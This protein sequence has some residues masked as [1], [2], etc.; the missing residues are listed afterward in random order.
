MFFRVLFLILGATSKTFGEECDPN[1]PP[2]SDIHDIAK[3]RCDS[4]KQCVIEPG[5]LDPGHLD[6]LLDPDMDCIDASNAHTCAKKCQQQ[7]EKEEDKGKKCQFYRKEYDRNNNCY[8][9][10][11]TISG[12]VDSMCTSR[13]CVSGKVNC[14]ENGSPLPT[15]CM[16][17]NATTYD[18]DKVHIACFT[19]DFNVYD[20]ANKNKEIPAE[21]FCTTTR[22]CQAWNDTSDESLLYRLL[23][24]E[25]TKE[26]TWVPMANTGSQEKSAALYNNVTK[27]FVEPEC[28]TMKQDCEPI[29][30]THT[31]QHG[32]LLMCDYPIKDNILTY[33]NSC[34]LMCDN[35][36]MMGID[37]KMSEDGEK[38]WL[39][40]YGEVVTDEKVRCW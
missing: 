39:D 34:M 12:A 25:C 18:K 23:G 4:G 1:L 33:P 15:S 16:I 19:P 31:D 35:H 28:E 29:T 20:P 21:T 32:L 30:L 9:S 2:C 13:T 40:N 17:A 14:D 22:K 24:I 38:V 26:G 3:I 8:C 7:N 37:C 36:F 5:E 10:L 11:Q 6:D 27:M